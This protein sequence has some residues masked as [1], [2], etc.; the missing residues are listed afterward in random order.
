MIAILFALVFKASAVE[1]TIASKVFTESYILAEIAAE[2]LTDEATVRRKMGIGGTGMLF[3]AL[4][5]GKVDL[6]PEYTGTI[7]ESILK[8]PYLQDW[9][10]IQVQLSELGLEMSQPLGF[11]NNY[12]IAISKSAAKKYNISKLSDL[13]KMIGRLRIGISSE[14]AAREDGWPSLR[15]ALALEDQQITT[16]AHELAYQAIAN[17]ELDGTDVYTTDAKIETLNL[18]VLKD[19]LKVFPEYQA[20]YLARKA[21][22]LRCPSCWMKIQSLSG[23]ITPQQMTKMNGIV[24]IEKK[25]F[26]EAANAFLSLKDRTHSQLTLQTTLTTEFHRIREHLGFVFFTLIFSILVGVPLGFISFQ[27][28]NVGQAVLALSGLLQTI[29]S[30]ALLCLLVPLFGIGE[31]PALIALFLYGLLPVVANTFV[32]FD[33]VSPFYLETAIAIGLSPWQRLWLVQLPLASRSIWAGLKTSTII[34]IGTATLAALIG[35]G[36]LGA[37]IVEGLAINDIPTILLGAVPAALLALIA[38]F[39]FDLAGLFVIPRGLR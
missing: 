6:Y 14:F 38:N 22:I 19:D 1:V 31:K 7:A 2:T 11:D 28:K 27:W 12:A 4:V 18:Q 24:D 3:E 39:V 29:P 16:L 25:G 17:G 35:A 33:S 5:S 8:K 34:T 36:G 10:E 32:G 13:K 23:Q 30:L 21:F 26:A 9:H 20:V 15:A 37:P